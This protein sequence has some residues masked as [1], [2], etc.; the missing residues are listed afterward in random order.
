M[1]FEQK[2]TVFAVSAH[3]PGTSWS[4]CFL[5]EG[6]PRT[7]IH[8]AVTLSLVTLAPFRVGT[9]GL[10]RGELTTLAWSYLTITQLERKGLGALLSCCS[11]FTP[12]WPVCGTGCVLI[13]AQRLPGSQGHCYHWT[14]TP[15]LLEGSGGNL[16]SG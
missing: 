3:W 7:H 2:D 4:N 8:S 12:H 11:I 10:E 14:Q 16:L 1:W 15:Y 9:I 5:Q 6:L 13:P